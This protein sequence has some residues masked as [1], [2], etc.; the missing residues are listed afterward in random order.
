MDT[1]LASSK[2]VSSCTRMEHILPKLSAALL[3]TI[4]YIIY[5]YASFSAI[6][7][8]LASPATPSCM[9]GTTW[10]SCDLCEFYVQVLEAGYLPNMVTFTPKGRRILTANAGEPVR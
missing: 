3:S 2:A 1:S 6:A 10:D 9:M 5:R 7:T 8:F 4:L